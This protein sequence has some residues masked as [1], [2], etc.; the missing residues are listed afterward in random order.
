MCCVFHSSFAVMHLDLEKKEFINKIG[1]AC[2]ASVL[3]TIQIAF[4]IGLI[5]GWQKIKKIQHEEK[6]FLQDMQKKYIDYQ[7]SDDEDD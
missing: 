6:L 3:I 2:Y 4:L 7:L 5:L 1:L